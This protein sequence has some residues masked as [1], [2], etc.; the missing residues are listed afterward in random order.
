[1]DI[2]TKIAAFCQELEDGELAQLAEDKGMSAVL[3]NARALLTAGDMCA[4]LEADLDALD[5]ML[6]TS[7]SLSMY[8]PITRG[9]KPPPGAA[10]RTGAQ[11]WTC[12]DNWCT[13]RG[14]VRPQQSAPVCALSG[15]VLTQQPLSG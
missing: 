5:L 15:Q 10:E 9:F 13:G 8:A 11:W 12:P 2:G 3:E 6:V 14:R 4:Q 1:M 7:G